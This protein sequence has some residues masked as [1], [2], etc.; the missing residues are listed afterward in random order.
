MNKPLQIDRP[1][2]ADAKILSP[3]ELNAIRFTG[4]HTILTPAILKKI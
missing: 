3:M 4:K 2:I 1:Q